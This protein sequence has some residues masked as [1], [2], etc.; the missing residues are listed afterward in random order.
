M[1]DLF[2]ARSQMA[3]SVGFRV[4]FAI[5]GMAMPALRVVVDALYGK[6]LRPVY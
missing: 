6:I 4:I 5:A 2:T 3:M 1:T